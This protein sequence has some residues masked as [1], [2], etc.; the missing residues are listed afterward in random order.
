MSSQK[1]Y[2]NLPLKE[3]VLT[4]LKSQEAYGGPQSINDLCNNLQI[5]NGSSRSVVIKLLKLGKIERIG[6]GI[7]RNKGDTRKYQKN[8]SY[9]NGKQI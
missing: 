9:F 6:H 7:Y 3:R 1:L 4:L 5:T 8:K 2:P